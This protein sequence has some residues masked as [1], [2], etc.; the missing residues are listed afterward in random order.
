[1]NSEKHHSNITRS[2]L[3]SQFSIHIVDTD[4][5]KYFF[6]RN[7][8]VFPMEPFCNQEWLWNSSS[9]SH[10]LL[11]THRLEFPQW[12]G[13]RL[14]GCPTVTTHCSEWPRKGSSPER[15][16]SAFTY[17]QDI[18]TLRLLRFSVM[19]EAHLSD[20]QSF[21]PEEKPISTEFFFILY[22][23]SFSVNGQKIPSPLTIWK[24][25]KVIKVLLHNN[26]F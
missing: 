7:E 5:C 2:F 20:F 21:S 26:N 4:K 17:L 3:F 22:S 1:M 14:A 15:I 19:K 18:L 16:M 8:G 13:E 23:L 24:L 25:L 11:L 9:S 12:A 6:T 10:L